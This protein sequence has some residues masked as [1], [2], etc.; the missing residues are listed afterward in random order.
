MDVTNNRFYREKPEIE[1]ESWYE[2]EYSRAGQ[3][4]W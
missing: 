2:V 1:P 3:E 4:D